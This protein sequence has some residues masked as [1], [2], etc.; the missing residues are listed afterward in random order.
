MIYN[1]LE[2]TISFQNGNFKRGAL[3][4]EE[5]SQW[6]S[7]TLSKMDVFLLFNRITQEQYENLN[8]MFL[9]E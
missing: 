8:S 5:Y 4:I 1:S 3:T 2:K 9:T 7:S 6:K